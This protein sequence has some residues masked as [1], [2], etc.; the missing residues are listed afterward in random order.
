[1]SAIQ[2]FHLGRCGTLDG[3]ADVNGAGA[4]RGSVEAAVPGRQAGI[5]LVEIGERGG[6]WSGVPAATE[7]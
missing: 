2:L 6:I 3:V 7:W 4:Y 1:M 5:A